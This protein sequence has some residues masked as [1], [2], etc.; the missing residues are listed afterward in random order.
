MAI[1]YIQEL[2]FNFP[3][4][5][6]APFRLWS[7]KASSK[8]PLCSVL[9]QNA[10]GCKKYIRKGIKINNFLTTRVGHNCTSITW[11][12]T[13]NVRLG[14]EEFFPPN[15]LE[16]KQPLPEEVKSGRSW[17]AGE[18]RQKSNEDLHKLWYIL[19]K[20][21]NML[22]TVQEEAKRQEIVMVSPE[23]L[24]KVK[25]SM[26]LIKV[27]LNER[28]QAIELIEAKCNSIESDAREMT[29]S[30]SSSEDGQENNAKIEW[31]QTPVAAT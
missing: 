25:K 30:S 3:R 23:R 4:F 26:A 6:I 29:N 15:M 1:F 22:L 9:F 28:K 14:I 8:Y 20:E 13:S 2:C 16:T 7:S 12:H 27:V 21:R 24:Q 31:S 17:R 19:L 10:F 5:S 18:L 11:I